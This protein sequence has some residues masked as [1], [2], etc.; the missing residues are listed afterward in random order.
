ML[1]PQESF[2]YADSH[3][4]DNDRYPGLRG[5]ERIPLVDAHSPGVLVRPDVAAAQLAREHQP[6]PISPTGAT[7]ATGMTGHTGGTGISGSTGPLPPLQP[8]RYHGT[9]ELDQGRVGW[10]ASRIADEVIARLSG[11]VGANV[12]VTLDIEVTIPSGAPD[13]V[14]RT[15]TEN[16]PTLNSPARASSRSRVP[17]QPNLS[18][19]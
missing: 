11:I 8:T 17:T 1:W 9:V 15:V 13:H 4:S 18:R 7:G 12:R 19:T 5:G 16:G 3:G 2:A 14:V 6:D 10:S